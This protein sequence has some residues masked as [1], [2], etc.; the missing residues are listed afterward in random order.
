M[1]RLL[2]P[3]LAAVIV[4]VS[5]V[6]ALAQDQA[7][8]KFFGFYRGSGV[9]E[10]EDSAYF[11]TSVRD[12]DVTIAPE[13]DGFRVSW[14]TIRRG[15]DPNN[16]KIKRKESS[17]RF[18]PSARPGIFQA[19]PQGDPLLGQ[20][21]AW[22]Q[23]IDNNLQVTMMTLNETGGYEIQRWD[24]ELTG[25]GMQMTYSRVRDGEPV[26]RVRGRLTREGN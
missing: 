22:A 16:P 1:L 23:V 19:T 20:Q 12:F 6:Q 4:W 18:A 17:M 7:L 3:A 11:R 5:A 9:A 13:G 10:D 26:R 15:G 21:Y 25:L 14:V 8:K 2:V 24:R